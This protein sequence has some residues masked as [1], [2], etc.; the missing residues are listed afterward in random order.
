MRSVFI[1]LS[2]RIAIGHRQRAT[3]AVWWW[4]DFTVSASARPLS[5]SQK[6]LNQIL[7]KESD[8]CACFGQGRMPAHR[9]VLTARPLEAARRARRQCVQNACASHRPLR[10]NGALPSMQSV[11]S[12]M[13]ATAAALFFL[14]RNAAM[15]AC[16]RAM[17]LRY[18][19]AVL[20]YGITGKSL[21]ERILLFTYYRC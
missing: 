13:A 7:G 17:I 15:C 1:R 18:V 2:W 21:G 10:C 5:L 16:A 3:S 4:H 9:L 20:R 19:I 6:L 12:F 11:I 8:F 14:P